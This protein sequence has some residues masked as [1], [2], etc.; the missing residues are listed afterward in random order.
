VPGDEV[1]ELIRDLE[2]IPRAVQRRLRPA[3]IG[4]GGDVLRRARLNA[5]W[6]SRIPGATRLSVRFS[7]NPGID[8]ITDGRRAPHASV[9]ENEGREGMKAHPLFGNRR[10]WY[11]FAAR[12]YLAPAMDAEAPAAAARIGDVIDRALWDNRFR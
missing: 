10:H 3:I 2:K 8:V 4:A 9:Y 1:G 7:R 5:S 11:R 12:P 6:S